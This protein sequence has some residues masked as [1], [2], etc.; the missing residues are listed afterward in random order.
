MELLGPTADV[1]EG[2]LA[3]NAVPRDRVAIEIDRTNAFSATDAQGEP[4]SDLAT[5]RS[6]RTALG[7]VMINLGAT[8]DNQEKF[9]S[10]ATTGLAFLE[11]SAEARRWTVDYDA[12]AADAFD[13]DVEAARRA[14]GLYNAY[15]ARCHTGGYAAGVAFEQ[16]PGAGGFGP[17]LLDGRAVVQFP[18]PADH[19]QFLVV[20]SENAK[21]YGINGTGRGWMPGFGF[22]LSEADLELIVKFERAL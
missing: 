18:D 7:T 20:G 6:A 9:L 21:P 13:G 22:V 3:A 14:T 5:V 15:C 2:F 1:L 17:S 16:E 4:R 11:E 8:R 12:L 19:L 10:S